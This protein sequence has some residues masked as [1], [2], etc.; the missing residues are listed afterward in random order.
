MEV[1]KAKQ[2]IIQASSELFR[3]FGYHKTSV[4]EIARKA[5]VAKA[6]I[7]KYFESKEVLLYHIYMKHIEEELQSMI[8]SAPE[9]DDREAYISDL[10]FNTCRMAYSISNELIGW[11][12]IRISTE[13][14]GFVRLV[15]DDMEKL[16]MRSYQDT[17]PFKD[18]V[19]DIRSLRFLIN[20]SKSIILS[21]AYTSANDLDIKK[22]FLKFKKDM[23]P[24]LIQAATR[25]QQ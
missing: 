7:Y 11:E 24:F 18:S 16:L 21:Y 12:F 6:T 1:D 22:N 2:G 20:S 17:T 13:L 19:A 14:Q 4:N 9:R 8:R 3:K 15:S 23:L 5:K 25:E 10:I